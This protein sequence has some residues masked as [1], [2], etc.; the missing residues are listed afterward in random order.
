ML[1]N[2]NDL[3]Q[4]DAGHGE[5]ILDCNGDEADGLDEAIVPSDWSTKYG[6]RDDGLIIDDDL[7]GHLVDSLPPG[8]TLI[9]LFDSCHSGTILDMDQERE[10]NVLQEMKRHYENIKANVICWTAC[11]DWQVAWETLGPGPQRG[12]M[13]EVNIFSQF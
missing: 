8:A 1:G 5:Q 13:T 4:I 12:R 7:R 3:G 2:T 11:T 6:Y 10:H 9:A